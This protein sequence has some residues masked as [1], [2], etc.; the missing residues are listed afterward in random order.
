MAL[1]LDSMDCRKECR[2]DHNRRS[3]APRDSSFAR[4]VQV[5]DFDLMIVS[6]RRRLLILA[7]ALGLVALLLVAKAVL[8]PDPAALAASRAREDIGHG[9]AKYYYV[10]GAANAPPPAQAEA[11]RARGVSLISTG[12]IP[13]SPEEAAY[14]QAVIEHFEHR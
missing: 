7:L 4:S 5:T 10:S 2:R 1:T 8:W 11:Y 13:L 12:C 6:S 14:N 3:E 9:R